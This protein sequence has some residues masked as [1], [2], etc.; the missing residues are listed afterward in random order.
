MPKKETWYIR[1]LSVEPGAD[2]FKAVQGRRVTIPGYEEF[3][4][5]MEGEEGAWAVTD[6][7]TGCF[8]VLY[9]STEKAAIAAAKARLDRKA[10]SAEKYAALIAQK[11]KKEGVSPRY[12][13]EGGR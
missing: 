3:D 4:F 1:L 9:Q 2:R 6:A 13:Q 11:E 5:F 8:V 10:G 12:R 7:R